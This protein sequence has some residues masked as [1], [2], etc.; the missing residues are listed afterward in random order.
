VVHGVVYDDD[1]TLHQSDRTSSPS[2]RRGVL[3]T[4]HQFTFQPERLGPV[5]H[6]GPPTH[7]DLEDQC[8]LTFLLL[9][10]PPDHAQPVDLP[11]QPLPSE[12]DLSLSASFQQDDIE[13]LLAIPTS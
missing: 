10:F 11:D 5:P 8:Q 12:L 3:P 9:P 1:L 2:T 4:P 13:K 6:A 7:Q